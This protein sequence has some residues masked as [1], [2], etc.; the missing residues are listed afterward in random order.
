MSRSRARDRSRPSVA[1]TSAWTPAR[2]APYAWYRGDLGVSLVGAGVAG[3]ADQSGNGAH[4]VQTVAP[5]RPALVAASR[6]DLSW[7][8]IDTAGGTYL[9]TTLTLPRELAFVLA[10]GTVSSSSGYGLSHALGATETHYVYSG[11]P[12]TFFTREISAPSYYRTVA[13]QPALVSQTNVIAQYDGA[14]ITLR[15]SGVDVPMQPPGGAPITNVNVTGTLRVCSG[16]TGSG[17][18]S[19]HL[20]EL[21]ICRPL[22][23][24]QIAALD[25]YF[26]RLGRP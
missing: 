19:L 8:A 25:A 18:A 6:G 10:L 7:P 16:G 5:L 3:W 17:G 15:R 22:T 23:A 24:G 26:A 2:L 1:P 9:E 4:L 20:I 12:A 11:G 13:T 14:A 21:I